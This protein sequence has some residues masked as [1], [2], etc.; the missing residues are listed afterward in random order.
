M[1]FDR[2]AEGLSTPCSRPVNA[3]VDDLSCGL[4]AFE[5]EQWNKMKKTGVAAEQN[6]LL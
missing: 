6:G 5:V 4:E 1:Y 2:E 3:H